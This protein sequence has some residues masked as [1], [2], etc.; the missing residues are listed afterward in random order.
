MLY[1]LVVNKGGLQV[2]DTDV[3]SEDIADV[4]LI[5]SQKEEI[6]DITSRLEERSLVTKNFTTVL[7]SD[8]FYCS[9][10][11]FGKID[12]DLIKQPLYE[13][14]DIEKEFGRCIV[15][16]LKFDVSFFSVYGIDSNSSRL[17]RAL[18]DDRE[19]GTFI[20]REIF[21]N[22]TCYFDEKNKSLRSVWRGCLKD[23]RD[24]FFRVSYFSN[25]MTDKLIQEM[26]KNDI[27][28]YF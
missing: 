2:M 28:K 10:H 9:M 13:V 22:A 6:S 1:L 25:D 16:E 27:T 14:L 26:N 21:I 15:I 7:G 23:V 20:E 11:C 17:C 3:Y 24:W 19:S 18:E 5:V 8:K 4:I 12:F